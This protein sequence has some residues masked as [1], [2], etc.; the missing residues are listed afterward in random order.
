LVKKIMAFC[1]KNSKFF[2]RE[3]YSCVFML[4]IFL[5]LKLLHS[6]SRMKLKASGTFL[7]KSGRKSGDIFPISRTQQWDLKYYV[8]VLQLI[9][10]M[11]NK[12]PILPGLQKIKY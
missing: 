3:Y 4:P 6:C 1:R 8:N 5:Y 10:S 11:G 7:L 2:F 9:I 12:L